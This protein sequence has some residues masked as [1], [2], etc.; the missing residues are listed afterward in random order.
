[1]KVF[2]KLGSFLRRDTRG[3]VAVE[4]AIVAPVLILMSAGSFEVSEMVAR[5][6]ELQ[7]GAAEATAVALA[8]NQGSEEVYL[9]EIKAMLMESLDLE[10]SEVTVT[11]LWRCDSDSTYVTQA[12]YCDGADD[13]QRKWRKKRVSAY[14]KI[15]LQDT[16]TPTWAKI[17]LGKSFNFEVDRTIQVS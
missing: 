7:G 2:A 14:V 1:M 17:G 12:S 3:A 13:D 9:T 16:W 11:K 4:T 15:E 5:Q 10:D 6:H 8:A